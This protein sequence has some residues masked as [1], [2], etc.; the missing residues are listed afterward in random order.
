MRRKS[1]SYCI[2]VILCILTY[3]HILFVM[4]QSVIGLVNYQI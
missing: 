2:V 3:M 1:K 4:G